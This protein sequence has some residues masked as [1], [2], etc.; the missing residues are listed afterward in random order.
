MAVPKVNE[1]E[2]ILSL[3]SSNGILKNLQAV[4]VERSLNLVVETVPALIWMVVIGFLLYFCVHSGPAQNQ[5]ANGP[6]EPANENPA[7]NF[8]NLIAEEPVVELNAE[9]PVVDGANPEDYDDEYGPIIRC[10][11]QHD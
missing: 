2:L 4:R 9:E 10:E 1:K 6:Y 3:L 11:C 5:T 7:D 8:D